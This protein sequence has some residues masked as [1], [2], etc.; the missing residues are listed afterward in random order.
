MNLAL[1]PTPA[2][3]TDEFFEI[4]RARL[5]G[6][7]MPF[8]RAAQL[9]VAYAAWPNNRKRRDQYM[10][11]NLAFFL[12][13]PN[14]SGGVQFDD[15]QS[16]DELLTTDLRD[17]VGFE[18]FGGLQT[19]AEVSL[20]SLQDDLGKIQNNWP[21]VAD[22]FQTIVDIAYERR[23]VIRGGDKHFQGDLSVGGGKQA[24]R[25][26]PIICVLE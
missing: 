11:T 12:S 6:G 4:Y 22:I 19:V 7:K 18:L 13:N 15:V 14:L 9:L 2:A 26:I 21:R 1:L 10:A 8:P 16:P 25:E 5:K 24:A 17:R 3:S 20:S 23:I